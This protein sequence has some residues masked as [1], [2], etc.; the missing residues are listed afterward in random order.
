ME[1]NDL[2]EFDTDIDFEDEFDT[3]ID[4]EDEF[5]YDENDSQED[6][7]ELF[8]ENP[9]KAIWIKLKEIEEKL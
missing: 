3:D 6:Q 4:F 9:L 8:R 7:E 5:D 1:E 2:D